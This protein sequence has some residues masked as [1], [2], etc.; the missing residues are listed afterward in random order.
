MTK[1]VARERP[2]TETWMIRFIAMVF[3]LMVLLGVSCSPAPARDVET[4]ISEHL[5]A[6]GGLTRLRALSAVRETGTVELADGTRTVT[7]AFVLEEK[8]PNMTRADQTIGGAT[9]VLAFDGVTAWA[10]RPGGTQPQIL[11]AA[12]AAERA[13]SDFDSPLVNYKERGIA[14]G[15]VGAEA[16]NGRPA[17]KLKVT[18][19]SGRA[20]Y[21]YL[22]Q[23][24]HLEVQ[25]DY[26]E[27]HGIITR[28]SF[29]DFRAFDGLVRPT[30]YTTWTVG[31]P[32]RMIIKVKSVD[33]N[34]PIADARFRPQPVQ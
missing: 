16:I 8:R 34:P 14:V 4:L 23:A 30:L 32:G 15:L 25:R 17:H 26:L 31:E 33:L 6:R 27:P 7:G 12:E 20:R 11:S 13:D 3:A 5:A 24:T 29:G 9:R 10:M 22:D 2:M 21:A 19:Q 1:E 28:Q 18:F